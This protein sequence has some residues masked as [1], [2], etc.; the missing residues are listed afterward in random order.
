MLLLLAT[1]PA[2]AQTPAEEYARGM[3]L[4]QQERYAEALPYFE[5][6]REDAA[7]YFGERS[8]E[9]AIELN[10]LGELYRRVG[11]YGEAEPLLLEALAIDRERLGADDPALATTMNNLGLLYR[12][13]GRPEEA[14][15]YLERSLAIL[16]GAYGRRHPDVARALNNLAMLYQATDRPAAAAPLLDRAVD[17]SGD[18]LGAAHPTTLR[19][20]QNRRE[21]E[22]ALAT[23][24]PEPPASGVAIAEPP[25]LPTAAIAP[26]AAVT[27]PRDP[28]VVPDADSRRRLPPPDGT[29]ATAQEAAAP[30]AAGDGEAR[31]PEVGA[32]VARPAPAAAP[33]AATSPLAER[34]ATLA[35][36][37]FAMHLASV[38]SPTA[39]IE[40]WRRLAR[41]FALPEAIRQ[42]EPQR[43]ETAEQGVFYRVLGGP[44]SSPE[45]VERACAPVRASGAYCAVVAHGR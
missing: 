15:H 19:L 16:E 2:L 10:N 27:L 11:R 35:P 24:P 43:V 25:P 39:A 22:E 40:E 37:D 20:Q 26:P 6:A 3:R 12:A 5:Q 21:L 42:I 28:L 38:R 1:A 32:V 14:E 45:A 36:G 23:A 41:S 9:H 13:R 18:L 29:D 44:F 7:R 8:A 4:F 33:T 30:A 34:W 31:A 17:I